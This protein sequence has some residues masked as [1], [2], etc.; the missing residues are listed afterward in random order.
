[1]RKKFLAEFVNMV[2]YSEGTKKI[3]ETI[4]KYEVMDEILIDMLIE[5]INCLPQKT[6]D[7]NYNI[8][9]FLN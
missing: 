1:M 4:N 9:L 3:K 6:A 2:N 8:C 7:D 5:E